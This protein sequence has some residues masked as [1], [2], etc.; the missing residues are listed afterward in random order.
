[1]RLPLAALPETLAKLS[2]AHPLSFADLAAAYAEPSAAAAATPSDEMMAYLT[3]HG[4]AA[5]LNAAVNKLGKEKPTDPM[6]FL[7][8][9][10]GK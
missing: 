4:V 7:I 10:L 9:E 3:Q 6:A 2:G 5:K 1:M 8:A